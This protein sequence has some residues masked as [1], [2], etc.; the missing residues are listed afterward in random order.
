MQTKVLG[1]GCLLSMVL[2]SSG[3]LSQ[4]V[5]N[6]SRGI[7][8]AMIDLYTEQAI[9]NL[10]RAREALP[11]VQLTYNTLT[12]NDSDKFILGMTGGDAA[13]GHSNAMDL[14]KAAPLN[15][16]IKTSTFAG[17]YPVAAS[18]ERDRL[19]TFHA[20]PVTTQ[21]WIYEK[22]LAFAKNPFQ[23]VASTEPPDGPVHICRKFGEKWYWVP[24]ESGEAFLDLVLKT[25]TSASAAGTNQPMIYW[26]ATVKKAVVPPSSGDQQANF[27][28]YTLTLSTAIPNDRGSLQVIRPDGT[29]DW[30]AVMFGKDRDPNVGTISEITGTSTKALGQLEGATIR[31]FAENHLNLTQ[32]PTP[33]PSVQ[34]GLENIRIQLN[35]LNS[36]NS[37]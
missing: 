29:K 20:Q 7:R 19:L 32:Q 33:G 2:A 5:A 11:F 8:Q 1:V 25:S 12:V 31:F 34:S 18:A 22:Y 36:S 16:V 27:F 26:E 4:Q 35:K 30:L 15:K 13:F 14:T 3:C 28:E 6:D 10:I 21:N 17:K 23:F 24:V 37:N 9:D